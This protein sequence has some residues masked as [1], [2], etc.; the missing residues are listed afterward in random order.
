MI[1]VFN[2][3]RIDYI[4]YSAE[5]ELF[6]IKWLHVATCEGC[7]KQVGSIVSTLEVSINNS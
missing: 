7:V 4:N 1:F 5:N 6:W 3:F 2:V